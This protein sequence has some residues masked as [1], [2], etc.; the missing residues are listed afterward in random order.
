MH[1]QPVAQIWELFLVSIIFFL[2]IR[3]CAGDCCRGRTIAFQL[4]DKEESCSNFDAREHKKSECRVKICNDGSFVK[5]RY[6]GHGSC[7]IF[8]CHCEGGCREGE[9]LKDYIDYYGDLHID[10]VRYV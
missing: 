10:D 3:P 5:G 6:C 9:G 4:K 7:N 1:F 8:G 2:L